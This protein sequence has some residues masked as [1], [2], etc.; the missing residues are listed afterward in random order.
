[1]GS[2]DLEAV[3]KQIAFDRV[4]ED[5]KAVRQIR[6]KKKRNEQTSDY[7]QNVKRQL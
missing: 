6:L 5:A 1:M 2:T 3:Y 7:K 4:Y